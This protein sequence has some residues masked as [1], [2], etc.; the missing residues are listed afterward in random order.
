[1]DIDLTTR[2]CNEDCTRYLEKVE[3]EAEGCT[4][5]YKMNAC[6]YSTFNNLYF[7]FPDAYKHML[8][9]WGI[10]NENN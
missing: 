8:K 6:I 4:H 2:S 5:D 10:D 7:R 9:I 1:M 3:R